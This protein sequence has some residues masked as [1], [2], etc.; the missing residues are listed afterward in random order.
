MCGEPRGD[1]SISFSARLFDRNN[2]AG[3]P[4]E[5]PH[6]R[7]YLDWNC[8]GP[9]KHVLAKLVLH[10]LSCQLPKSECNA[11]LTVRLSCGRGTTWH[12]LA[13]LGTCLYCSIIFCFLRNK[14]PPNTFC[15]NQL[16][17]ATLHLAP[18]NCLWVIILL[19]VLQNMKLVM[20]YLCNVHGEAKSCNSY[21][22]CP[23]NQNLVRFWQHKLQKIFDVLS[24]EI[25]I[26]FIKCTILTWVANFIILTRQEISQGQY[27]SKCKLYVLQNLYN[28]PIN[29]M[30]CTIG[31]AIDGQKMGFWNIWFF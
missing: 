1:C 13:P 27:V 5:T 16:I 31:L 18:Q 6:I 10:H 11:L 25:Q 22:S 24:N 15:S 12:H 26:L 14:F 29:D 17:L 19:N 4:A 30:W 7:N 20:K 23:M 9:A 2:S 8:F 28:Y 3:G 21:N